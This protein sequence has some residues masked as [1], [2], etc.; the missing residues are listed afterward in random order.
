MKFAAFH[1]LVNLFHLLKDLL[2]L[3]SLLQH[4]IFSIRILDSLMCINP[5]WEFQK[6][7]ERLTMLKIHKH[8]LTTDMVFPFIELFR[9]Y[10]Q[11]DVLII[12]ESTFL[13]RL[14]LLIIWGIPSW[15]PSKVRKIKYYLKGVVVTEKR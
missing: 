6:T 5:R 9:K 7:V 11:S 10:L 13:Q 1:F 4:H 3:A 12:V 14:L 8:Q 2:F 15:K